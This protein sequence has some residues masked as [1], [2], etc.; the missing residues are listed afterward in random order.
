[1]RSFNSAMLSPVILLISFKGLK[2]ALT[3]CSK[4]CPDSL[5]ALPTWANARVKLSNRSLFPWDTS[6][7]I[8][9]VGR[10][11]SAEVPKAKRVWEAFAKSEV[12]NG[13]LAP[14]SFRLLTSFVAS[15]ALPSI[16]PKEV[17]YCSIWELY[18]TPERTA[19]PNAPL[20]APIAVA[21]TFSPVFAMLPSF[22]I[23]DLKP[24]LS[25]LVSNFKEP[26]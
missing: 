11:S 17:I 6:P 8:W 16:V 18:L 5:P 20:T 9:R 26:S 21:V 13:V 14:I 25:T 7:S 3:N 12:S 23:P 1:M 10:R 19:A 24:E 2:P 22:S 4:S 15:S